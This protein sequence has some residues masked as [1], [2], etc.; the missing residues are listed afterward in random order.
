MSTEEKEIKTIDEYLNQYPEEIQK[1]MKELR[2]IILEEVP[3]ATEKI[4]WQMP[5]FSFYGALVHF[6]AAKNHLGF[7]PTPSGVEL[8]KKY[9]PH[10][11]T[12][13][14][15]VQIPYNQALPVDVIRLVLQFRV[16]ENLELEEKK[17]NHRL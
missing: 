3:F 12:T 11:K 10:Y 16:K 2:K 9:L 15:G 8:F 14:G 17:N 7:Y 4:S 1:M 6:A 13:K 5:T